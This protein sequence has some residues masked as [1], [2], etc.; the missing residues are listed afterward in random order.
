MSKVYVLSN[1]CYSD[2]HIVGV[3]STRANAEMAAQ[4]FTHDA[5]V[6]EY[7]LDVYVEEMRR[8]ERLYFVR[9]GRETGAL[10]EAD[11][12]D[13]SYGAF[14]TNVGLDINKNL[15]MRV[16]AP[17]KEHAIKVASDRRRMFLAQE[18]IK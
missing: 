7:E 14:D 1:G 11:L 4:I 5:S 12:E 13:S 18:V 17:N 8:D 15:Y 6:D 2:T 16:W 3:F 9:L 10:L